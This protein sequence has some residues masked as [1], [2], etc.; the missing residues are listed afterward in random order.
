M[1]CHESR[2]FYPESLPPTETQP[3]AVLK[4]VR[5]ASTQPIHLTGYSQSWDSLA[6]VPSPPPAAR[7]RVAPRAPHRHSQAPPSLDYGREV[8]LLQGSLHTK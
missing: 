4:A 3:E 6:L 5:L 2:T 8:L 1:A 7:S